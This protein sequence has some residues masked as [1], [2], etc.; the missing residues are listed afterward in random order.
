MTR[1]ETVFGCMKV[2]MLEHNQPHGDSIEEV[3]RDTTV[4][5]FMDDLLSPFTSG[6]T[7]PSR[8]T[9]DPSAE[10]LE[11]VA[12][13]FLG[14]S[15]PFYQYYTD[16]V[17]LY[18]S[19][20]FSHPL[21]AR[22]LLPPTSMRYAP[23]YRKHLWGDFRH[24]LKTIR[25][26]IDQMI[27]ADLREYLWPIETDASMLGSYLQALVKGPLEGFIRLIAVHHISC[28]IWPDLEGDGHESQR[29]GKLLKAIVEQG[30]SAVAEIVQYRQTKSGRLLL[31]PECFG[32]HGVWRSARIAFIGH[33]LGNE[34][35][36]RL[37]GLLQ[38]VIA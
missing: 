24:V 8:V 3:F 12:M 20:S 27:T 13:R 1:E 38:D 26:P 21:F 6:A 9:R 4:G 16:F 19:I 23:D 34:M 36:I 35:Q 31:P 33:C 15:I 17:G 25:T 28:N 7:S 37:S 30:G 10:D 29:A 2:F 11:K 32:Q 18:D 14:P 5:K 22:L